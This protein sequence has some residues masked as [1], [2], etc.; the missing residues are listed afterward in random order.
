MNSKV[1]KTCSEYVEMILK[2]GGKWRNEE[3]KNAIL[4]DYGESFQ[5][6]TIAKYLSFKINEGSVMSGPVILASGKK[7]DEYW[8]IREAKKDKKE[9]LII[10]IIIEDD[11][12]KLMKICL[13]VIKD[14]PEEHPQYAAIM[15][16]YFEL[17]MKTRKV[18]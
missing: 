4:R 9:K 18:A 5:N 17:E 7:C 13:A 12:L 11:P 15:N 10:P 14:Y 3:I 6:N 8:W 1:E 2:R 16:Q